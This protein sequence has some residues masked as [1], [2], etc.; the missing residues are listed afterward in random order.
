MA[1]M[2]KGAKTALAQQSRAD[3]AAVMSVVNHLFESMQSQQGE[4]LRNLFIPE[5]R[6]IS[7]Q[8]RKGQASVRLLALDDFVKLTVETKE[9]FRERMFRPEVRV[10]GD[11]A[12]VW[13]RYDFHVGERLTNCG[14]NS[15][16]LLRTPDG[17]KIAHIASTI[18]TAGCQESK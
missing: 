5:G 8:R 6:L 16:Q 18:I 3:E 7:T 1:Q 12:T 17:W 14:F 13:G 2:G 11:M 15:F 9:P 10:E 4:A